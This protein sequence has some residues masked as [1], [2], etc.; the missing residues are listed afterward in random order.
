MGGEEEW[1]GL[2]GVREKGGMRWVGRERSCEVGGRSCE[3]GG[4]EVRGGWGGGVRWVGRRCEVGGEEVRGGWGG[5]VRWVGRC[6]GG[7]EV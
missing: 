2:G 4:E 5:G 6:E 1:G 3:V 7:K